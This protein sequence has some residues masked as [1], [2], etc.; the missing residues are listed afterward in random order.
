MALVGSFDKSARRT[1]VALLA[2]G[3]SLVALAVFAAAPAL[4]ATTLNVTTTADIAANANA[5]GNPATKTPASPLS[6]RE[7]VCLANNIG[8]EVNIEIPAGEYKLENG[9]LRAGFTAGQTINFTGAGA[10]STIING[11]N[12]SRVINL[13]EKTVG[14]IDSTITGLTV[15]G[16]NDSTFGG[17]GIIAGAAELGAGIDTLTIRSCT[18]RNNVA[19]AAKKTTTNKPGGGVAMAAGKLVIENSLIA[20]NNSY[21]SPGGGVA[22]INNQ[23][24]VAGQGMLIKNTTFESNRVENSNT[25]VFSLGGGGLNVSAGTGVSEV[26]DSRFVNNTV[27]ASAGGR[28]VGGA[29][30]DQYSPN[31]IVLRSTFIGNSVSGSGEATGSVFYAGLTGIAPPAVTMHFNRISGNS[32]AATAVTNDNPATTFDATEN[33]WGCNAGPGSAGC[34]GTSGTTAITSAP[35]LQFLASA[36]PTTVVGPGGTSTLSAGFLTDSASQAVAPANL[37]AFTGANVTWKEPTPSP[38]TINGSTGT[39]TTAIAAGKATATY[40]SQSSSGAGH[41]VTTFDNET[42]TIALTVDQEP[43]ITQNPSNQTVT[44]GATATFTAAASGTPTPS[45]QWQ[46]STD[47]GASFTNIA[48]ATSTTYSFTAASGENGNQFRAVFTNTI[49]GSPHSATTT[50]ATLTVGKATTTLSSTATN[51][52]LG[53]AVHDTATLSGGSSPTGSIIFNAY[54]PNDATCTGAIA[55]TKTVTVSGNGEYGSTNF[56]ATAAGDYRWTIEYSGDAN[57][58]VATSACNATNEKSTVAKVGTTLS[59]TASSAPAP[60]PIKDTA[61]LA[62]GSSPTGNIVFNAYG[63]NDASCTGAVAFTKTVAVSGNGSYGSTNF[64]PASA[65]EYRWTASYS[66]DGNNEGSTSACNAANETSTVSKVTPTLSTAATDAEVGGAIHDTATLAGGVVTPGGTIVFNA[67]EPTDPTCAKSAAYTKTVTVSGNGEYGSGDFTAPAAGQYH[68]T[69]VYSGD[70]NNATVT[71][72]CGASGETS[73]VSQA[74]PTISTAATNGTVGSPVHDTATIAGGVAPGGIVTFK[75]YGPSDPECMGAAVFSKFVAVNGNGNYGSTDFTPTETGEYRW[76]AAY[77]GDG[78]NKAA[79]ST[80]GDAGEASQV[81]S[82]TPTISTAATDATVGGAIHDTATLSGGANPTGTIVFNA[83]GPNDATCAG[84]IAFTKTVTVSGNGNYGSTDFTPSA[85]GAYRW[86]AAYSGDGNNNAAA[87]ACGDSGETSQVANAAPT[88]S[89]GATDGAIGGAVH[90]TATL[91]GGTN[92][93]GTIVFNAYGPNDSTCAGAIVFTKTVTVSGN[94]SYGSTDFTPATAG[95]YNWTAAYSGDANNEG[96]TSACGASGETSAISQ[97]EPTISTVATSATVGNPVHDT[98]TIAGG[99]SAGGNIVFK[100][101]APGDATCTGTP[102]FEATVPVSGDGSYSSD[103]STAFTPTALGE[104]RWT[105]AYS[106]DA[107]NEAAASACGASGETSTISQAEPTI[108]TVATSATVGN[109]VHDTATIAGGHIAGGNIVF[110][111]FAPGDATCTGTPA[112]EATVPV[113]GDGSYSSDASTAFT[114]TALGVYRW[115]AAYSGDTD[116]KAVASAC[117]DAGES[118][119]VSQAEPTLTVSATNAAIGSPI[120][121]SATIAGGHNAGGTVTFKAFAPG[122]ATCTG[123][124]AFEATILV[125]GDGTYRSDAEVVFTPPTAGEYRWTVAYS[126]DTD[127]KA[128]SSTCNAPNQTSTVAEA[129]PTLT[130]SATDAVLGNPVHDTATLAGGQG[131]TGTIVFEAFA[132][133]DTACTAAPVFTKTVTVNGNGSYGSGDFTPTAVGAYRW[134][135]SYS[136]D[137]NN[138]PAEGQCNDAGETSTVSPVPPPPVVNPVTPPALCQAPPS[139]TANGYVPIKKVPSGFVPGVRARIVVAQPSNLQIAATLKYNLNGKSHTADLGSVLLEN[140]GTR[141]LRLALPSALRE[142][143]PVGTKVRL[144]LQIAAAPVAS[145]PCAAPQY[146]KLAFKTKVVNVLA[147]H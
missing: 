129:A 68:W 100:A 134:I 133:S 106:G 108:S 97:A 53:G 84:A 40:N 77:S 62:G 99:H 102:A 42:K 51:A 34:D 78:N 15:T 143:L 116:N 22:F 52:T 121:D 136:G 147:Q 56:T 36:S 126:G 120:H 57:N 113:S 12:Q 74:E 10:A 54:G 63:P 115:T 55:F 13:D 141:N 73:T 103:A 75:A 132:P 33:W 104:Y 37:T 72:P 47:G 83:Y 4:A 127:N 19:N 79:A 82:A 16:G 130:T 24:G 110:K 96:A 23:G 87:S 46:R 114:P 91:A 65:G 28:A 69:A 30:G 27:T 3:L 45:V 43:V 109:P 70:A 61:T 88:I 67:Y 8:G 44:P 107:N 48:G 80:C 135:A 66:G 25:G 139:A 64:S 35:R 49:E 123:T 58:K 2:A 101:F 92:P 98:A 60:G 124:P 128:A 117:N 111:A 9:E 140:P 145:S 94:G 86:T 18:I 1:L 138:I 21:S 119:T 125:N 93:S 31:L 105:A 39:T 29:I 112:F 7:A 11:Q 6:L 146:R 95:S 71:S 144:L 50:A 41:A 59:T 5:C 32:P 20:E 76:T 38:A 81:A 131:P 137:A 118:S 85:S 122:D 89:T 90:D 14:K 26:V 17:G 142:S